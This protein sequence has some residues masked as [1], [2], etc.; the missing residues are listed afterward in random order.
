MI[1]FD[2]EKK[3]TLRRDFKNNSILKDAS[4]VEGQEGSSG[5]GRRQKV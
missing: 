1:T 2:L 4:F 3:K 5:R